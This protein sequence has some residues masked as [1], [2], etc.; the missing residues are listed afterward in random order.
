MATENLPPKN[1]GGLDPCSEDYVLGIQLETCYDSSDSNG[2]SS[3]MVSPP[4]TVTDFRS[5]SPMC[6][7][8]V[9]QCPHMRMH[10][11]GMDLQLG[12]QNWTI[13]M[14]HK[15]RCHTQEV[16]AEILALFLYKG[17][18]ALRHFLQLGIVQG[19]L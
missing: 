2:T 15:S 16:V 5:S 11:L 12:S 4:H 3:F 8:F 18:M 7:I 19:G 17:M 6:E 14:F 13:C 9:Y 10:K 1:L